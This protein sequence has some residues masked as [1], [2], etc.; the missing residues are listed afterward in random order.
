VP[1]FSRQPQI[2]RAKLSILKRNFATTET[3]SLGPKLVYPSSQF[4][5]KKISS[6]SLEDLLKETKVKDLVDKRSA[7]ITVRS[8]NTVSNLLE[9]LS[10]GRVLGAAVLD[11]DAPDFDRRVRFVDVLDVVAALSN[12]LSRLDFDLQTKRYTKED[13]FFVQEQGHKLANDRVETIIN[14]SGM[15]PTVS[16]TE[17]TPLRKAVQVLT[18][19]HRIIVRTPEG[20]FSGILAQWDIA[21]FLFK[22]Y[23]FRGSSFDQPMEDVGLIANK[24]VVGVEEDVPVMVAMKRMA[25]KRFSGIA[26]FNKE[27]KI[28]TNLSASDFLG[29][30][31]D[32]FV[33]L[34]RTVP[35]FLNEMNGYL[36]TPVTCRPKDSIE[37]LL[38]Q[39]HQ[40]RVHRVYV[41][42]ENMKPTGF[43]SLTDIMQF[44]H[45]K[46][47]Y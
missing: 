31:E 7:L 24:N 29:L 39:I 8:D 30:T 17:E 28:V 4:E 22:R 27:G 33:L 40:H 21:N 11:A 38:L 36:K 12:R 6:G 9:V 10:R 32:S 34:T 20:H 26:V 13:V 37:K 25:N 43:V 46:V 47:N 45:T 2:H 15:D 5:D 42:D 35:E 3:Q 41:V 1:S 23:I 16:I 44:I 14:E 18:G 19:V